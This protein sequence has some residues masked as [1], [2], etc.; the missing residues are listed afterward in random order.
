MQKIYV[1]E[2]PEEQA[3]DRYLMATFNGREKWLAVRSKFS[4]HKLK[5]KVLDYDHNLL[6]TD[7]KAALAKYGFHTWTHEKSD[8]KPTKYGGLSFVYNPHH[9]D[10]MNPAA[11][12][13]GTQRN[14]IGQFYDYN[15]TNTPKLKNSYLDTY[16]FVEKTELSN[17]GYIKDF[18]DSRC[19]RTLVRSRLGVI[20]AGLPNPGFNEYAW[21]RDE[22][23]CVNL[24]INIPIVTE[25][26]YLFQMKGEEPYHLDV[27]YAY[28]WD[29]TIPHRVYHN[30][31]TFEDRIHFVLGFSP[32][33]DYDRENRCWTKNDFFGKHPFQMVIDGDIFTGLEVVDD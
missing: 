19:K 8:K 31:N 3:I 10:G 9:I 14:N 6:E 20:K 23:I 13:L 15:T 28:T 22:Q 32:W 4:S 12:T 17:F 30:T 1:D 24:R 33:F 21:H 11:S 26:N 16:S 7:T 2:I 25:P 29:T 5:F 18:L 27:G